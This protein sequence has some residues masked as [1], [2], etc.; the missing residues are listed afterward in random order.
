MH[1]GEAKIFCDNQ[2]CISNL[3]NPLYSKFTNHVAASFRYAREAMAL[4]QVDILY[5]ESARN[6]TD[7]VTKPLAKMVF[8][9]HRDSL[10]LRRYT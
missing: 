8:V 10:G 2:G 5:V 7:I 9:G 4:G 1:R 6:L 3:R